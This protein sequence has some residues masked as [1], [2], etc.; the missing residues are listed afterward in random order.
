[1]C[2]QLLPA[3]SRSPVIASASGTNQR[4]IR[5]QL[6]TVT[7]QPALSGVISYSQREIGTRNGVRTWKAN[8]RPG[9][10]SV[11]CACVTQRRRPL[12]LEPENQLPTA[13]PVEPRIHRA[14]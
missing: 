7:R 13:A 2:S 1:M 11:I 14:R 8:R 4:G 6:R 3:R 5:S 9:S 10:A 12:R